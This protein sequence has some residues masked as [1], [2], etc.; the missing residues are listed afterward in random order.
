MEKRGERGNLYCTW[1]KNIILEK[2]GGAKISIIWIIYTPVL[3]QHNIMENNRLH[4]RN[5]LIHGFL[6]D[7]QPILYLYSSYEDDRLAI[8]VWFSLQDPEISTVPV[9]SIPFTRAGDFFFKL[10]TG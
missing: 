9:T 8:T 4:P 5:V 7:I 1:E 6:S 10:T 3:E 2:G